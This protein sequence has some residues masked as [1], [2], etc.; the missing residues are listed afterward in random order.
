MKSFDITNTSNYLKS[1]DL[2]DYNK[3]INVY[4][5]IINEF[6]TYSISAFFIQKK[7]LLLFIIKR[8]IE[9]INNCFIQLFMYTKNIDLVLFH[10]K[11]AFY[12]YIEFIG[13]INEDT[14]S[15]LQ[16][17]SK[18]AILFVYKKTIFDID[19]S[20]RRNYNASIEEQ[21]FIKIIFKSTNA[22]NKIM[23]QYLF[24]EF[25]ND[26]SDKNLIGKK[27]LKDTKDIIKLF[28][29]KNIGIILDSFFIFE[30]FINNYNFENTKYL[31]LCKY[32]I[33]KCLKKSLTLEKGKLLDE[34]FDIYIKSYSELKFINW[35][36]IVK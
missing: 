36:L 5:S 32:L 16:L 24:M 9:T 21:D 8:G 27:I 23:I 12:Y 30:K 15:Y 4:E 14:H 29:H 3:I 35:L 34:K 10:C 6:L 20:Y 25:N 18:D 28:K 13:Q 17:T 19:I 7:N 31:L 26:N 2:N 22:I 11:K 1:H 33:K